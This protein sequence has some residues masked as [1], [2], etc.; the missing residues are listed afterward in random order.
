MSDLDFIYPY[1]TTPELPDTV[2]PY[3]SHRKEGPWEVPL[4][5]DPWEYQPYTPYQP[6]IPPCTEPLTIPSTPRESAPMYSPLFPTPRVPW[7]HP[8]KIFEHTPEEI[9]EAFKQAEAAKEAAKETAKEEAKK[10]SDCTD[11]EPS[12]LEPNGPLDCLVS[13]SRH[14]YTWEG[15][16]PG[17]FYYLR[18][19]FA[20]GEVRYYPLHKFKGAVIEGGDDWVRVRF[21]TDIEDIDALFD[22]AN[23]N[24]LGA[25]G[26]MKLLS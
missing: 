16:N 5:R 17:V 22:S 13:L 25:D 15:D 1:S 11:E 26:L 9:L 10:V 20:H 18:F 7:D 19:E 23:K 4:T 21:A 2:E 8:A 12:A 6:Y 3:D 14:E 24:E